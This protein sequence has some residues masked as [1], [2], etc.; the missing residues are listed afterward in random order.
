MYIKNHHYLVIGMVVFY[1]MYDNT[2]IITNG[3]RSVSV[4]KQIWYNK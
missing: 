4:C 2:D 3:L 1:H